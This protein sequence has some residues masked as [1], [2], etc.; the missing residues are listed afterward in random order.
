MKLHFSMLSTAYMVISTIKLSWIL[1]V[2]D[3]SLL[4]SNI[5]HKSGFG[6]ICSPEW[7]DFGLFNGIVGSFPHYFFCY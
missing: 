4:E 7:Y 5:E 3:V 1:N 6:R 2:S